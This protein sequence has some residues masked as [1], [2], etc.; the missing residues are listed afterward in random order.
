MKTTLK[1]QTLIIAMLLAG[2][3]VSVFAGG[4][5]KKKAQEKTPT[6]VKEVKKDAP[7]KA[8]TAPEV[9]A[10]TVSPLMG[11]FESSDGFLVSIITPTNARPYEVMVTLMPPSKKNSTF[12]M[13]FAVG[14]VSAPTQNKITVTQ[15]QGNS[16]F[17]APACAITLEADK[18]K[19]T[20]SDHSHECENMCAG[21]ENPFVNKKPLARLLD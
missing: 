4:P 3:S 10:P 8:E 15:F 17:P 9:E 19:I 7:K 5:D 1:L 14:K 18:S 20:L 13:M 21:Q 11:A 2:A 12:C 6:A 16:A